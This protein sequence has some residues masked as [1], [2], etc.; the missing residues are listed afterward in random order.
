VASWS[1]EALAREW[2]RLKEWL[3]DD[4]GGQ[5]IMRHLSAAAAAWDAMGRPE[6][7]LYRGSRLTAAQHWRESADPALTAVEQ[8]FLDTAVANETATLAAAQRQ[9]KR[10]RRMVRRL[11]WVSASAAGLAI[12]AV[13]AGLLAGYQA[14]VDGERATLAEARRV[15]ALAREE[16]DLDRALLTA[17]QA[18]ELWDSSETRLNLARVLSRA[19]RVTGVMR[20]GQD[21]V[22]V[23][24]SLSED[25]TRAVVVDDEAD[26]RLLDLERRKTLGA[27]SPFSAA[28]FASAI[29]PA[30][31]RIAISQ[32][33]G[34]CSGSSCDDARI[35][36]VPLADTGGPGAIRY[37]GL[38][39][40]ATDVEFSADGSLFAA[41]APTFLVGSPATIAVWRAEDGSA[42]RP[43]ILHLTVDDPDPGS[44]VG[45][46]RQGLRFSPDG[47]R[48]YVSGFG[49]T[50]AFDT[51]SGAELMQIPGRG[52]LAVSPDGERVAVRDGLLSV[53][54]VDVSG[55]AEPVTIPLS[56]FA[57][58]A[59]FA[60]DSRRLAI[61][62]GDDILVADSHSGEVVEALHEHDEAV[63]SVEFAPSGELVSTGADGAILTWDLSDWWAPAGMDT[64]LRLRG[65]VEQDET[66]VALEQPD[67]MTRLIIADPAA[68][69]KRAC[70]I[71]GR[72]LTAE[73]WE[74]LLGDRAYTPACQA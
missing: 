54:I 65:S 6:T 46:P 69:E 73:E 44:I 28:I 51:A 26:L 45:Q 67:R 40:V 31:G 49:P 20:V 61:A 3:A 58:A 59:D 42:S 10:E 56:A 21:A 2:R 4:V 74:A 52:L 19:P 12:A 29:D 5:R 50:V 36:T 53:R 7:E 62:A 1:Q 63:V 34:S 43:L 48:L 16:R 55:S 39:R 27:Y 38:E 70:R 41:L 30:T 14:N 72:V 71:A 24:A 64:V 23:T 15:A 37:E 13:A 66:M 17:V 47:S 32:G 8:E 18:I 57:R 33:L 60:P 22:P 68:W 35:G 11:S 9:L 25:G